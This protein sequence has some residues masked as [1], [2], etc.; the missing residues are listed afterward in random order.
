MKRKTRAVSAFVFQSVGGWRKSKFYG[1]LSR[2]I[3]NWD[4]ELS[5][6]VDHDHGNSVDR[7]WWA[8]GKF[9]THLAVRRRRPMWLGAAIKGEALIKLEVLASRNLQFAD[10]GR[11]VENLL[12]G[13]AVVDNP[14]IAK[15]ERLE[16]MIAQH[17][18]RRLKIVN[19]RS[20]IAPYF[21]SCRD[22]L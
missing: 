15:D 21:F 7:R 1:D 3:R 5:G 11:H 10:F 4:P 22:H 16:F 18:P 6:S 14:C 2:P 17:E 9:S 8:A 13:V 19:Q 20:P 12:Q